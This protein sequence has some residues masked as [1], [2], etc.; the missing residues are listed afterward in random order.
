MKKL[1]RVTLILADTVNYSQSILSLTKSLSQIEPA[2][3]IFFT[4]IDLPPF[5][6]RVEV[7]KIPP[8]KSKQEYSSFIV[9]EI[10]KY[11]TTDFILISQW[12]A[13]VL[14]GDAWNDEFYNYDVVG[15]PWLY[16]DGRNVGNG[17]GSL[18]SRFVM[19]IL[20]TDPLVQIT[21]PEDEI[22][23]RLYRHHLEEKYD[24]KFAPEELA[25]TFSYELRAPICSTFMH[26]SY[27]HKPFKE[28]VV[29]KRTGAQGDV[30][31][32]EPL[33]FYFH[34]QGLRVVLDTLPQFLALFATH[35]F[36][37]HQIGELD[38]RVMENARYINLDMAYE[39][40]PQ[41]LHLKSYYEMC[42][43]TDGPIVN[44]RLRLPFDHKDPLAKLFK[45]YIVLHIDV[46]PQQGRNIYGVDWGKI[47]A[48]LN[49]MDF[50]VVQ[51][52]R[53]EHQ[54]I[55]GA[56]EMINL[57]EMM[58]MRLIGAADFMIGIDSGPANIAV[59]METPLIVFAGS[60]DVGYIYPDKTNVIVIEY[61]NVCRKPKCWHSTVSTEGVECIEIDGQLKFQKQTYQG[62][63]CVEPDPIPP[64]VQFTTEQVLQ[65]IDKMI[66]K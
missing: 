8:I 15:A 58:L 25:D 59:A 11:I 12:D 28:V 13:T 42:G 36:K 49:S 43:I 4:D 33:L 1:D 22:L 17:G 10:Y 66:N 32:L 46:R 52:G 18:R 62:V 20:A 7:I 26:H 48:Y 60:V 38:G 19:Q 27:F 51:I 53:G 37:V 21:H 50:T 35:Y 54:T 2:R 55:G 41:Q 31:A 63:E 65:A 24:V 57:G 61:K 44:P 6:D 9:K 64:C 5:D 56:I 14:D 23:G 39:I 47:V 34:T 40:R 29:I 30:V 3:T 16:S 45:K